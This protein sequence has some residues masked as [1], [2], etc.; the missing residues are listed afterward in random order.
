[1]S[2]MAKQYSISNYIFQ[3]IWKYLKS[4]HCLDYVHFLCSQIF[5][6]ICE[7]IWSNQTYHL[8]YNIFLN[9]SQIVFSKYMYKYK[10]MTCIVFFIPRHLIY[11][12]PQINSLSFVTKIYLYMKMIN[13]EKSNQNIH[14]NVCD[15]SEYIINIL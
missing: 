4:A 13:G 15:F 6:N 5:L 12:V 2:H 3:N 11:L 14:S 7:H 8:Y 9:R 10:Y 1:M